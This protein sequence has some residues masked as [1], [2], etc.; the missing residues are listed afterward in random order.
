VPWYLVR[1]DSGWK[2]VGVFLALFQF[3][4][5]FILLLSRERKRR[6]PPL[7]AMS[8]WILAVHYVDVYWVVMPQASPG[9][10][11]PSWMDLSALLGVG[12][13]TLAFAVWRMRGHPLVPVRDPYL[14]DSL[15]YEP[16]L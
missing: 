2:G 11:S 14:R 4:I 3:V 7:V 15:H 9:G 1:T 5:P 6:F 13:V 8:V 10:P 16:Q 12:G